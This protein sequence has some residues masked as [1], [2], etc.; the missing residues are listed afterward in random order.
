MSGRNVTT[1][2]LTV[3]GVTFVTGAIAYALYFDHKRRTDVEFRR[4]LRA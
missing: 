4:E 2:A 3:A 1:T